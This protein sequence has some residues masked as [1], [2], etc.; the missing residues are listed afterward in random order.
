MSTH[1]SFEELMEAKQLRQ[2]RHSKEKTSTAGPGGRL[3]FARE[4]AK[5]TCSDIANRTKIKLE[6]I[7]A[8]ENDDY[9]HSRNL[10]FIRGWLRAYAKLVNL[11]GDEII[12]AFNKLGIVE[13][14]TERPVYHLARIPVKAK[15]RRV[16][17]L[18]V[19][20][21]FIM[22]SLVVMWWHS[23]KEPPTQLANYFSMNGMMDHLEVVSE[24]EP[25]MTPHQAQTS[26]IAALD[27]QLETTTEPEVLID[28]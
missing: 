25:S 5:L 21:L 14:D 22:V 11:P 7:K 2:S 13:P 16:R 3:R 4:Q 8:I 12:E 28:E 26:P 9:S 19:L 24:V 18:S 6:I 20:I 10:V 23:Q 27:I 17:W 1:N 15:H